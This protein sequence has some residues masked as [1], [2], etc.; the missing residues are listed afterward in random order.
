MATPHGNSDAGRLVLT[1]ATP[2]KWK[3]SL[4]APKGMKLWSFPAHVDA[5]ASVVV[6]IAFRGGDDA[7]GQAS[8]QVRLQ[9]WLTSR[10]AARGKKRVQECGVICNGGVKLREYYILARK[11][12]HAAKQPFWGSELLCARPELRSDFVQRLLLCFLRRRAIAVR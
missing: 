10:C 1:N 6:E 9:A 8:Y 3:R 2:Y 7:H 12:R 11:Y 4:R 5:G